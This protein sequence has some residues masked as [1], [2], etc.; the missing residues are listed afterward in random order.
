MDLTSCYTFPGLAE[1]RQTDGQTLNTGQDR[2]C[3]MYV[4]GSDV[5][6]TDT[7]TLYFITALIFKI[8]YWKS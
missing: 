3:N 2:G 8:Y 1:N 4:L 7:D 6:N 5:F